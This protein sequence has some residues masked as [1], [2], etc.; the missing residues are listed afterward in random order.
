MSYSALLYTTSWRYGKAP[1]QTSLLDS[2]SLSRAAAQRRDERGAALVRDLVVGEV[3]DAEGLERRGGALLLGRPAR[4]VLVERERVAPAVGVPGRQ[5]CPAS[6]QHVPRSLHVGSHS[7][8]LAAPP[9]RPAHDVAALGAEYD[10]VLDNA[11]F[12]F[13]VP[14]LESTP[15]LAAHVTKS[16]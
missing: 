16:G 12:E 7:H 5:Q 11:V 9:H 14:P 13:T 4:R 15:G 6:A 2:W 3:H 1:L 8:P 10:V